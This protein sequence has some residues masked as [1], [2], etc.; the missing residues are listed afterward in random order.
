L[1]SAAT[2]PEHKLLFI[3][4]VKQTGYIYLPIQGYINIFSKTRLDMQVFSKKQNNMK[5]NV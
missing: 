1:E 4:Y 2:H 3:N 5:L